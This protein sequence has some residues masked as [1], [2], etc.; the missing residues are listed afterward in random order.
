MELVI[1]HF[2][3][4]TRD[5]LF[6]ILKL[7]VRVFVVEQSC[8]YQEIDDHDRSAYHVYFKD[9]GGIQAYLRVLKKGAVFD[10]AV[11]LGRVISMKRR[12][13]LAARLLREGITVAKE[14]FDAEKIVIEAQTY[15]RALYE[16]AGFAQISEEFLEDGIPH[17][18]MQLLL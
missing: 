2:E 9:E 1:K 4:L 13:G 15:A 8:A 16:K 5:E 7:R 12:C 14:K 17:I 11:S 10:D 6:E 3:Q 18:K